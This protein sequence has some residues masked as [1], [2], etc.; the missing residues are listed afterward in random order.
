M[1]VPGSTERNDGYVP[2]DEQSAAREAMASLRLRPTH[3]DRRP[4]RRDGVYRHARRLRG[5]YS[6]LWIAAETAI[7]CADYDPSLIDLAT[8]SLENTLQKE[9]MLD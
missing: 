6:R 1:P 8:K 2:S 4:L 5:D 7:K 9:G 3:H